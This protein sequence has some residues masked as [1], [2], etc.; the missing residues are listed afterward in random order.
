MPRFAA[1]GVQRG[2]FN[3]PCNFPAGTGLVES[4]TDF[5][6]GFQFVIEKVSVVVDTVATGAG[7]SRALRIT[8]GA[9]TSAAS[10]TYVLADG[11]PV[12]KSVDLT[13]GTEADRTFSDVDTLSIEWLAAGAVAFTAGRFHLVIQYR[14]KLQRER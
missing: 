4:L 2:Q 6:P 14:Q 8:K 11:T 13:L 9:S 7:A 3:I 10:R 5:V 1:Y 12:G